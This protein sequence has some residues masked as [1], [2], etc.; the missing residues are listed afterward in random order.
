[1]VFCQF[2]FAVRFQLKNR[3][4][5]RYV[6]GGFEAV[7]Q[8]EAAWAEV[9]F[10]EWDADGVKVDHMCQGPSCGGGPEGHMMAPQF[11]QPTI[12]RWVAAIAAV[13]KTQE[14][15]FQNCGIGCAPATGSAQPQPWGDW[16]PKTA[17][18]WRSGGDINPLFST[19]V[20]EVAN[21]AGRG[22]LSGPGGW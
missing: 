4:L 16:C 10:G 2:N 19:I 7:Y 3:A 6:T 15:L 11:Q 14:V 5:R 20:G 21:L 22:H 8:Q 13:N 9:M 12:E 1:M 17:N 18:M